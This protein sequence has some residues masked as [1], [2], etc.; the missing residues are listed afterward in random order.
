MSYTAIHAIYS[1]H[2]ER[3]NY[4][5]GNKL[6]KQSVGSSCVWN[7]RQKME[8]VGTEGLHPFQAVLATT[9]CLYETVWVVGV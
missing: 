6:N 7:T 1:G 5:W 4:H 2:I 3:C 9:S 8:L